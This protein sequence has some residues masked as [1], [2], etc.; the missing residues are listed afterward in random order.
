L[1]SS[2]PVSKELIVG[3]LPKRAAEGADGSLAILEVATG[4]EHIA[5]GRQDPD[6]RVLLVA[7]PI[8]GRIQ[9]LAERAVDGVASLGTG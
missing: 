1:H 9:V 3:F 7:K 6:P 5:V 4:A 2:I 8:P